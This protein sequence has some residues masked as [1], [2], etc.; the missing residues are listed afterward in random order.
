MDVVILRSTRARPLVVHVDKV[1]P[2][3]GDPPPSLEADETAPSENVSAT[4]PLLGDD[5]SAKA[6]PT[7][8]G[9]QPEDEPNTNRLPVDTG[10]GDGSPEP[11][12]LL[13][14]SPAGSP[15]VPVFTPGRRRH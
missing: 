6:E 2:F 11:V 1:K 13:V 7:A 3:L 4:N 15:W 10:L 5:S 8:D 9:F 12:G 14:S